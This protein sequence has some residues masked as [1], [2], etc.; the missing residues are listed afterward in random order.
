MPQQNNLRTPTYRH[1]K[2][3]GQGIV[4]LAGRDVYLGPHGTAS[5]KGEYGR[6]GSA[7]LATSRRLTRRS[8]DDL[9]V[10][11]LMAAYLIELQRLTEM[12]PGEVGSLELV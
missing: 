12:R 5:S 3:S 7:W 1:H 9:T 8:N 11:E 10:N 6:V 2:A 4:T